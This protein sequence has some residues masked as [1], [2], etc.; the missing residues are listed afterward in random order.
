MFTNCMSRERREPWFAAFV[1]TVPRK[2]PARLISTD[3]SDLA[4]GR[5]VVLSVFPRSRYEKA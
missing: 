3:H 1:T 5:H 2:L 4:E